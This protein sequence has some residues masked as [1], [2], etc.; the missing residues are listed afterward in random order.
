MRRVRSF[1]PLAAPLALCSGC[2]VQAESSGTLSQIDPVSAYNDTPIPLRLLGGPFRPAVEIDTY[3]GT[4]EVASTPFQVF[5][6]P[7]PP[8]PGRRSIAATPATW[9]DRGEIDATI[10]PGLPAGD[11]T[12]GL[13][14][15]RGNLVSPSLMFRSL[16]PDLDAPRVTFLRPAAGSAVS[17]NEVFMVVARVDDR[18]GHVLRASWLA[19]SPSASTVETNCPVGADLLCTFVVTAPSIASVIEPLTIRVVAEDTQ[20]N[21]SRAFLPLRVAQPPVIFGVLPTAGPTGGGTQIIVQGTGLVAD[22]SAI[23][24]DG[25][26]I[27]GVVSGDAIGAVTL[28]HDPG[29]GHLTVSNGDS[30]SNSVDFTFVARPNVRL[31]E[32]SHAFADPPPRLDVAGNDFS[33]STQF[34]WIDSNDVAHRFPLT[35][36]PQAPPPNEIFINSSRV[37]LN[38]L[39]ASGTITILAHDDVSGDSEVRDAF[40]FDPTP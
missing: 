29:I 24:V 12:V 6:D 2:G 32:P 7:S 23:L 17:P 5:L 19:S 15:P 35:T 21:T 25:V 40:T 36:D 38:L 39:P 8:V 33:E 11:Y 3:S 1:L 28:A 14:D 27:G 22:L 13:R 10:P 30:H 20:H 16:G 31:I 18:Q 9:E 26:S 4:A 34:S 37:Q